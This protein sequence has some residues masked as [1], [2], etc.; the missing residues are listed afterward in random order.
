VLQYVPDAGPADWLVASMTT[1]AER[2]ASFLPGTF[3]AYAR[4]YHPFEDGGT[5]PARTSAWAEL[6]AARGVELHDPAA[7]AAF[8]F[9]GV[10]GAQPQGGTLPR[11]LIG[12]LLDQLRPATA[13]PE[14][15][16]FAI[17]DGF[18]PRSAGPTARAAPPAL[19]H[20][21][22]AHRSGAHEFLLERARPP[23]R[24][25]LVAG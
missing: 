16:F 18:P 17:W 9:E 3:E 5:V 11:A 15:C 14:Q 24:E 19:P 7:A 23:I 20:L 21:P 4:V 8:A 13:T 22:R 10:R 2:V 6:A 25:S 12:P 1:F